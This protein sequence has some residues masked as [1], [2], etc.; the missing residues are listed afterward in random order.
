MSCFAAPSFRQSRLVL[1]LASSLLVPAIASAEPIVITG[2][3]INRYVGDMG[4]LSLQGEDFHVGVVWNFTDGPEIFRITPGEPFTPSLT[5][6]V[7]GYGFAHVPGYSTGEPG[8]YVRFGGQLRFTGPTITLDD[9]GTQLELVRFP[10]TMAGEFFGY[11]H[12]SGPG[13]E[14]LFRFDLTGIATATSFFRRFED[15]GIVEYINVNTPQSIAF[16]RQAVPEPVPE[17]ATLLLV[18]SGLAAACARVR[19][20][21]F[22]R[23]R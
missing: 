7:G 21:R 15:N 16:H 14:P 12:L 11:P 4:G 6:S 22:N 18:T 2:G 1:L 8:D 13:A 20:S 9:S 17:P 5:V 10:L 3:F 23:A 19:R